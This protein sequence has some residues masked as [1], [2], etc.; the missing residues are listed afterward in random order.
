MPPNH[1]FNE[2]L[3]GFTLNDRLV[4]PGLVIVSKAKA[5]EAKE[6]PKPAEETPPPAA[7]GD[8]GSNG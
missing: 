2:I 6:E 4:R 7:D 5:K 8:G 3:R 1:V